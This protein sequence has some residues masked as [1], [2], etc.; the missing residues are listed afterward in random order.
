MGRK[1]LFLG[2]TSILALTILTVFVLVLLPDSALKVTPVVEVPETLEEPILTFLD[3]IR[4]YEN[5]DVTLVEFGD[6][7]CPLCKTLE[8]DLET[9]I[10]EAPNERR[11]I[12]K[13]APNVQAHP[14]A[15]TLAMAARCA[16]D[17]G[18]FWEFHDYLFSALVTLNADQL[19]SAA[20]QLN[21]N[22]STFAGCMASD[23]TRPIV[24][25]TLDE[26][27]AL[28]ITST[29]T[30]FINGTLYTGPLTVTG[31]RAAIQAL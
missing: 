24:Q 11:L 20:E 13:D 8:A 23:V 1:L 14:D 16:Q 26:A 27:I 15:F 17:Q 31:I 19:Q 18:S 9:L 28:G 10:A 2:V 22:G 5:A 30:L 6:Y 12:W 7:S 25:H 4:G 29:P 21:L 3:P